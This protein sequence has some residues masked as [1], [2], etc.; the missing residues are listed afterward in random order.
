MR[1]PAAMCGL[2]PERPLAD[3]TLRRPHR[4][5]AGGE[6]VA[7]HPLNGAVEVLGDLVDEPDA[8]RDIGVE[9]L[10]GQEVASGGAAGCG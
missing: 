6:E 1:S 7:D 9:P 4:L 5:R 10:A 2:L 3:E 8:E